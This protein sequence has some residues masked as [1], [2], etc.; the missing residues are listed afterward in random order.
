MKHITL[1]LLSLVVITSACTASQAGR[2]Q[3]GKLAVP[4]QW[5]LVSFGKAGAETPVI[6]GSSI[7]LK[8]EANDQVSGT[9]GC[10]SYGGKYETQGDTLTFKDI[11][12]TLKAC[13]GEQVSQQEQRYFEALQT[14]ARIEIAADNLT[15]WYEG[16]QSKLNFAKN[17][18]ANDRPQWVALT[19]AAHG[20]GCTGNCPAIFKEMRYGS[21]GGQLGG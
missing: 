11:T 19:G 4:S 3:A 17:N 2:G 6:E 13:A 1:L 12:S 15:I 7:T 16:G 10:N 18:S 5:N 20:N 8:F 9:G 21:S 14:A